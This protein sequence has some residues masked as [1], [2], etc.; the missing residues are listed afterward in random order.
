MTEVYKLQPQTSRVCARPIARK[1]GVDL[2]EAGGGIS[3]FRELVNK[4]E[5]FLLDTV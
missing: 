5:D 4:V 2:I 3:V 1:F